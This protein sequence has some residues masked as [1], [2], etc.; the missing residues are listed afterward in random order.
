MQ[1]AAIFAL[2]PSSPPSLPRAARARFHPPWTDSPR[3]GLCS[4]GRPTWRPTAPPAAINYAPLNYRQSRKIS[5]PPPP[6]NIFTQGG[7]KCGNVRSSSFPWPEKK[8]VISSIMYACRVL[9][10]EG[11]RGERGYENESKMEKNDRSRGSYERVARCLTTLGY[12]S[13]KYIYR[14]AFSSS[15]RFYSYFY[16]FFRPSFH[17]IEFLL[18][19][20]SRHL[21]TPFI[22]EI[23]NAALNIVRRSFGPQPNAKIK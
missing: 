15:Y 16:T 22:C 6:V 7:W 19:A 10:R 20:R 1:I 8:P 4:T 11:R 12:I 3:L 17:L 14:T 21:L 23:I 18:R 13:G 2:H 9:E 5:P